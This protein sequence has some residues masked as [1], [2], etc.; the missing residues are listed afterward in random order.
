[1]HQYERFECALELCEEVIR[2]ASICCGVMRYGILHYSGG[3]I[4]FWMSSLCPLLAF[5]YKLDL[6]SACCTVLQA[7]TYIMLMNNFRYLC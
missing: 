4:K 2:F 6:R 3:E 1:M 7:G 5:T